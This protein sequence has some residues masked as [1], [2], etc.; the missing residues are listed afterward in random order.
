ML[1][2]A[3]SG[4]YPRGTGVHFEKHCGDAKKINNVVTQAD[5]EALNS[6]FTR[7]EPPTKSHEYE[8][9]NRLELRFCMAGVVHMYTQIKFSS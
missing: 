1:Q 7:P 6:P 9:S 2:S 5:P 8:I 4:I 3:I